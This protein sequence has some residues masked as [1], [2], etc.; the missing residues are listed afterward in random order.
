MINMETKQRCRL[1]RLKKKKKKKKKSWRDKKKKKKKEVPGHEEGHWGQMW[2]H[3]LC[4]PLSNTGKW[5]KEVLFTQPISETYLSALSQKRALTF[6]LSYT[7]AAFS[8]SLLWC[9]K[10]NSVS[11]IPGDIH[12]RGGEYIRSMSCFDTQTKQAFTNSFWNKRTMYVE[13]PMWQCKDDVF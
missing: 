10:A 5:R 13:W 11:T 9:L 8:G 4:L 7:A 12:C 6:I 1:I 2:P 3:W